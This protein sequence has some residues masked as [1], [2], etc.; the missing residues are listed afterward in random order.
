MRKKSSSVLR[1]CKRHDRFLTK[2]LAQIVQ[3]NHGSFFVIFCSV[4]SSEYDGD[5]DDLSI[6]D[7]VEFNVTSKGG[8][9]AA[10][11]LVKLTSGTIPQEVR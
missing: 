1:K 9:V 11:R 6:G 3:T 8:K 2:D 4:S 7:E 5:I 10:E